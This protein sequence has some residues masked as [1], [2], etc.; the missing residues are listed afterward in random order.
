MRQANIQTAEYN[1][2]DIHQD[3]QAAAGM[4]CF[5]HFMSERPQ[6]QQRQFEC[7]YPERYP[8]NGDYQK[9]ACNRVFD[10]RQQAAEYKPNDV[11][12][13]FHSY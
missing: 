6:R 9:S 5:Y 2:E 1:P 7:L 13:Y 3:R 12:Y 10:G 11:S 4:T 8:N